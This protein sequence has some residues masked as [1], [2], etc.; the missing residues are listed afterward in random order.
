MMEL[1]TLPNGIRC[2]GVLRTLAETLSSIVW[3][4]NYAIEDGRSLI[5]LVHPRFD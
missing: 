5:Q 3:T 1:T 4:S 2:M